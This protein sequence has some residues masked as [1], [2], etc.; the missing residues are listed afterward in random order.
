MILA[1]FLLLPLSL[2]RA[3]DSRTGNNIYVAKDD[4]ISGNFYAVGQ[5]ITIDGSIGGDL[6]VAGQTVNVNG[7][8][9][10]DVIAVGQNITVNGPVGGN[11]RAA[12]NSLT[13][14]GSV[15]RN[16]SALG[17]DVIL[18]PESHVGWDV[19]LAG[20]TVETRGIIDD[21]LNGYASQA[22]I[23]GKVGKSVNLNLAR[24]NNSS[25]TV[26]GTAVINGDLTYSS[27]NAAAIS[28]SASVAGKTTHDLPAISTTN[29]AL[30]WLWREMFAIFAALMVG[31]VLIF[32]LPNLTRG[33]LKK[34]E[35]APTKML[36]PGLI[37]MLILPPISLILAFTV[38]GLPLALILMALWLIASYAARI[39]AALWL[40]RLILSQI[41]R[42]ERPLAWSLILGV[43]V[44]WLLGAI[45]LVGWIISL[46]AAWLGLGAI[47]TYAYGEYRNI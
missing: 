15:A 39:I 14:N 44:L 19:Y 37:I 46:L 34:L 21:S 30:A 27:R 6:I 10:G 12:G 47:W 13:V 28:G 36:L 32:G 33:I 5:N 29:Q 23:A 25:L 2:A 17:A 43:I 16:V 7:S 35:K 8:V 31:L 4:V 20:R 11:I 26:A 45:P 40:G 3:A 41:S 42:R 1:A 24:N 18:G 9:A 38:I 22:L